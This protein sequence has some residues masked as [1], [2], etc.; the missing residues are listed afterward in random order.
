VTTLGAL[1]R[2]AGV[3]AL[4][5]DGAAELAVSTVELDSRRCVPGSVF[6]CV[7]GT[8]TTGEAFVS[9]ALDRG[10]ICVVASNPVDAPVSVRVDHASLRG[11][12]A[13]LSS[14][15]VGNPASELT[16]AGVTGTNGK[17]TVTWLLH[18]ILSSAGYSSSTIGTLTGA[19]TTPSAPELHRELRAA[20]DRATAARSRG[21][22]VMEVSSHALDQGRVDGLRFDVSVF[23]NLSHEH[24]DYHGTMERYYDAKATLFEPSRS[25][26]A[27]ICVDDEWGR[28]LAGRHTVPTVEVATDDASEVRSSIGATSFTWRSRDI[29]TQLTG[30]VN[31]TN[32]LLALEAACRLE[33]EEDVASRA[34]ASVP[35]VPG[36]LEVVA[37]GALSVLVDYAHTP[38]ALERVLRDLRSLDGARRLVVVFGCG[39]DRDR[40][41]RPIMGSVATRL[42]DHVVVTSDNPRSEDPEAII[43]EI[44]AGADGAASIVRVVDRESA[45]TSAIAEARDGDVVLIAGRGHETAQEVAGA[46]V[47]LDD[48]TVARAALAS[49][50]PT[51]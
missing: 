17:T 23:T 6:V 14:A 51:C 27:V 9:E 18:G 20:A 48:R 2:D 40:S 22:V 35:P 30:R 38:M 13:S 31:V 44:L 37:E 4:L 26:Q 47:E 3:D 15:V 36:R 46:M 34:I 5:P 21:A 8:A 49:R 12:L 50:G 32:T 7:P 45:I 33:V 19:R 41:K 16:L 29:S 11:T 28:R 1:L 43:D 25:A 24:L 42:A 39:G 10:A